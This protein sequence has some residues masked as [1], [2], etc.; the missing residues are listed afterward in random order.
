[1]ELVRCFRIYILLRWT[2]EQD[3]DW[4]QE[5]YFYAMRRVRDGNAVARAL[6]QNS[7]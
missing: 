2:V 7:K 4:I 6:A 3:R 1:M 5:I